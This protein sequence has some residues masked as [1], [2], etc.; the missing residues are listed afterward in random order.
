MSRSSSMKGRTIWMYIKNGDDK[1]IYSD[2]Y[3]NQILS[4][5]RIF[6]VYQAEKFNKTDICY[7]NQAVG[8]IDHIIRDC[9]LVNDTRYLTADLVQQDIADLLRMKVGTHAIRLIMK[10]YYDRLMTPV[11]Q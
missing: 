9:C 3:L 4:G 2:F 11:G 5:H 6:L 7:C 10:E 1:R 8:T